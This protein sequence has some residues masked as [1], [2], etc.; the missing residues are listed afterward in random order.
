MAT[1]VRRRAVRRV[2][3][4]LV[5]SAV[6]PDGLLEAV[7]G[8][9]EAF[10]VGVQWHPEILVETDAG[11]LRLAGGV[12][13]GGG[14]VG[15]GGGDGR[16]VPG[17]RAVAPGDPGGDRRGDAAAVRGVHRGVAAVPLGAEVCGGGGW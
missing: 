3:A 15:R 11:T 16:G 8:T 1:S 6:S 12:N 7:E 4:G 2:G 9:G 5:A 10:L 17:G 13:G 14:G